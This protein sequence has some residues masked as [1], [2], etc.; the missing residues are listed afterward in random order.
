MRVNISP[1]IVFLLSQISFSLLSA[2]VPKCALLLY[3]IIIWEDSKA[4]FITNNNKTFIVLN[5]NSNYRYQIQFKINNNNH[6]LAL[7]KTY[8][9]L[10]SN[11]DY[12]Y[13]PVDDFK[14][15]KKFNE[16]EQNME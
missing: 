13:I 11:V 16:L 2:I 4:V 6:I 15:L 5:A 14:Q 10:A 9:E 12:H 8:F 7:N 1:N 3:F